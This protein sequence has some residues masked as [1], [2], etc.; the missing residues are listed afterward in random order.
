MIGEWVGMGV[1]NV[2]GF[3]VEIL[4]MLLLYIDI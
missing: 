2:L 3:L 1:G 4:D